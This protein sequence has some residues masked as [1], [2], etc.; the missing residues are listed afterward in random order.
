MKKDDLTKTNILNSE[1]KKVEVMQKKEGMVDIMFVVDHSLDLVGGSVESLKVI[2]DYIKNKYVVALFSPGRYSDNDSKIKH[3]HH[4]KHKSMKAMIKH[5]IEFFRYYIRLVKTINEISPKIIHTQE[6]I[7]Y[8]AVAFFKRM[9]WIRGDIIL[10]HTER[11]LYEKY[12]NLIKKIF[13]F[14]LP[15]TNYVITTTNYNRDLWI[16]A[17]KNKF[18]K[19][20][21]KY[22]VIENTAGKKF[23]IYDENESGRKV[24]EL[25]LGFAG[26]YCSWKGWELVENICYCLK[27]DDIFVE[28]VMGCDNQKEVNSTNAMFARIYEKLGKRFSGHIN[29]NINEM[30]EFYYRIDVF[31][32]TSDPGTESFGRVLV[33]AM[34]RKVVVIGTNCGG[35]TEVIGNFEHILNTAEEFADFARKLKYDRKQLQKKAEDSLIRFREKYSLINNIEKHNIL[36]QKV[37]GR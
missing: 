33:E 36:Y 27:D 28:I 32:I 24:D 14:S 1:M 15:Y 9:K 4:S 19:Y 34:S 16:S 26:R 18:G 21:D 20:D 17:V 7:G 2:M 22:M 37:I 31:G 6:Q 5:P 11:G 12:S 25:K 29:Y 3:F 23:E 35:A 10:I 30:N 8:F 13:F